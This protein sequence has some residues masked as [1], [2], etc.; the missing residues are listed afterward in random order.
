MTEIRRTWVAAI[1]L[2]LLA[3]TAGEASAGRKVFLNGIDLEN[4]DVG[5]RAF[6]AAKIEFDADGNVH[7]TVRGFDIEARAA[8]KG[9]GKAAA[10]AAPAGRYFV[11]HTRS[12]EGSTQYDVEVWVNGK[13][14][15][16]LRSDDEDAV[17]EIT[18]FLRAGRNQVKI[19]AVKNLGKAGKRRSFSPEHKAG[20][21]IGE[22][23]VG[24]GVVTLRKTVAQWECNASQS[25]K[26]AETYSFDAE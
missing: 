21:V 15:R 24:D 17:V 19:V 20:I 7:I 13:R 5:K 2:A 25:G 22:G 10:A 6:D 26:L 18:R 16:S 14:A 8:G 9:K 12:K 4:V 11:A 23:T 1:V 3:A